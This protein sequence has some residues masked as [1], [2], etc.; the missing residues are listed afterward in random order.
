MLFTMKRELEK[1]NQEVQE[2]AADDDSEPREKRPCRRPTSTETRIY[3]P[4][5]RQRE[6][7]EGNKIKGKADKSRSTQRGLP[8]ANRGHLTF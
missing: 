4:V 2:E 3:D 7:Q 6:V 1:I 5:C 8:T